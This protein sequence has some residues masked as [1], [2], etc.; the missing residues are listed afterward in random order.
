[1]TKSKNVKN[2][3]KKPSHFSRIP[4]AEC[5][6]TYIKLLHKSTFN[7]SSCELINYKL[8]ESAFGVIEFKQNRKGP[9]EIV[10]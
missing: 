9:E 2:V 5:L 4:E 6:V 1:M 7:T 3:K 10:L 8:I